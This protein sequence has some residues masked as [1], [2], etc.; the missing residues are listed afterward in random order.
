TGNPC[1][2]R[3]AQ[4]QTLVGIVDLDEAEWAI[5]TPTLRRDFVLHE[6]VHV[7][8]FVP[9]LLNLT[10]PSGYS[11]RCLELP[12]TGAPNVLIQDTHFSCEFGRAAFDESQ[13][14]V[15]VGA[16]VPLEN[17]ATRP[18][19]AGTLNHH[20]RKTVFG[21]E[22]MTGWFSSGGVSPFSRVTLGML[23]DLGYGVVSVLADDWSVTNPGPMQAISP[24]LRHIQLVEPPS[25][26]APTVYRKSRA[27]RRP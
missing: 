8:G 3:D 12:S 19:G 1:L 24:T 16:R 11:R 9:N 26:H 5:L 4:G 6:M 18:L 7:L 14:A 21:A 27:P 20:W 23:E 15:Y 25:L 22:L 17:G 2:I 13:G 10:L